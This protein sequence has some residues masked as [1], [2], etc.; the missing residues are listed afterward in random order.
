MAPVIGRDERDALYH[1]IR[2]DLR[3]LGYLAEALT[4]ERPTVAAMLAS[5]YRAELRLVDDLGWAP[6]DPREQF[7]L[8]L[9]EPDLARAM[10]RLLN[11]VVLAALDRG[12]QSQGETANHAVAVRDRLAAAICRAVVGEIDPAIVRDAA[13][14]LPEGW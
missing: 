5:R 12:D 11:G 4:D 14:P 8:T 10:L 2:R 1:A 7:E 6:V 13:E 9:P 3:F